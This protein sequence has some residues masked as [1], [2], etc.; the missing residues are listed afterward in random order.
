MIWH[1]P[2]FFS[3]FII[4][5][6]V[7]GLSVFFRKSRKGSMYYSRFDL[8]SNAPW[9]LR[10]ALSPLPKILKVLG[11][12][13]I[14]VALARPQ[15]INQK[16][17]QNVKGVDIMIVL[18]ISLSMLVEDMGKSITRLEA[19][20]KVVSQFIKGR[21]SDRVGLIVFS[22]ESYTR[23]P[24]TLDYEL[25]LKNLSQVETTSSIKQGTA[26]GVALANASA[27]L[28]HSD[29][30]SRIIVFLTDGE[31]NSGS[32]DPLTSLSIVKDDNIKV[33]PIG[34]GKFTGKVPIRYTSKNPFGQ[35]ITRTIYIES[36]IN[37]K[38]MKKMAKETDGQFFMADN[39]GNLEAV[40]QKINQLEKQ[41]IEVNKWTE[42]S[43]EFVNF[44]KL[45]LF[46]YVMGLFLLLSVFFRGV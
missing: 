5:I 6:L 41:D 40:F 34:V 10:S 44:L 21:I 16:S 35:D 22:G 4:L 3:F 33:Y 32:I 25:L 28:S 13:L 20:K 1:S 23:V 30:S 15:K 45:G 46:S 31:N 39:L 8:F 43:E 19:A 37:K 18:D 24:L 14:I 27:R 26:I 38:L 36:R 11:I 17:E 42:Y 12:A 2:V 7:L 29:I 9:T